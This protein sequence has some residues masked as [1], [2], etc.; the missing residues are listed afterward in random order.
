VSAGGNAQAELSTSLDRWVSATNA[1]NVDQ[2][3]NY[4]APKVNAY[5]QARNASPE[6]VRAEKKRL[7]ERADQVDI[8]TGKP[9]INVSP[10][11]KTATMRFR[12]KYAIKEGQRS[13]NGEVLQELKWVKSGSGW[14]IVSERD[15]KVINR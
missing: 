8:Q 10:D 9:E 12:K 6:S 7:F 3:M 1:R 11:G 13:R 2:Q 14:R 4:Y 5:Y 15:I